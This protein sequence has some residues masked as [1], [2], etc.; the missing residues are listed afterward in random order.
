[1]RLEKMMGLGSKWAIFTCGDA[2]DLV[3]FEKVRKGA[4]RC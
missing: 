2:T 1:M 3:V 4:L